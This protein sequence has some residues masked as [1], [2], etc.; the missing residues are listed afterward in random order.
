MK[1][2]RTKEVLARSN[3]SS[4]QPIGCLA[5]WLGW[6]SLAFQPLRL[7]LTGRLLSL[8]KTGYFKKKMSTL[9]LFSWGLT[10]VATSL[11]PTSYVGLVKLLFT[12]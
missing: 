3:G 2:V 10:F 12:A 11:R 5:A 1:L 9:V 8:A 7:I 4:L 6:V